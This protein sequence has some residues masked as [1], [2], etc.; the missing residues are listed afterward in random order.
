[1]M[2]VVSV[3]EKAMPRTDEEG[4]Y[5]D[6]LCTM[7]GCN[8]CIRQCQKYKKIDLIAINLL[9]KKMKTLSKLA[10]VE[11]AYISQQIDLLLEQFNDLLEEV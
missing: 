4:R 6:Y 9:T 3:C 2:E 8:K 1:M 11:N 5:E 10:S 7:D